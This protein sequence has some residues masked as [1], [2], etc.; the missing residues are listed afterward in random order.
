M[1][2]FNIA[3]LFCR[4]LS[5]WCVVRFVELF[6][7]S[8]S[9]VFYFWSSRAL[10][11]PIPVWALFALWPLGL[12][13]VSCVLWLGARSIARSIAS[14]IEYS[15]EQN[16][17]IQTAN[18]WNL[19]RAF[20]GVYF[21]VSGISSGFAALV[22]TFSSSP[23]GNFYKWYGASSSVGSIILGG[24]LLVIARR[25]MRHDARRYEA[26]CPEAVTHEVATTLFTDPQD[27][28]ETGSL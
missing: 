11:A 6:G 7:Q 28:N 27:A 25:A 2:P 23:N 17:N 10:T 8:A 1:T 19:G 21:L 14:D 26:I 12:A 18:W 15:S 4:L 22:A 20:L 9:Q 24:F 5:I 3:F 16:A 13:V